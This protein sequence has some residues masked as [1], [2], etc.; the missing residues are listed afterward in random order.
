[1]RD[2]KRL[3]ILLQTLDDCLNDESNYKKV[4]HI[5]V[6]EINF[7]RNSAKPSQNSEQYISSLLKIYKEM[8]YYAVEKK[9]YNSPNL[10]T[11]NSLVDSFIDVLLVQLSSEPFAS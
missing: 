2:K 6:S 5:I 3:K 10:Y 7:I 11:F 8:E 1:M 9:E 4:E